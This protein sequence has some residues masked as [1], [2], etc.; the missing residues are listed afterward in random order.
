MR[1]AEHAPRG[2][3]RLL[4]C[5]H[6]LPEIAEGGAVV[7]SAVLPQPGVKEKGK[8]Y[9]ESR[10]MWRESRLVIMPDCQGLGLG[11][12]ISDAVAKYFIVERGGRFSSRTA[13]PRFGSY[14][15]RSARE[16]PSP[17]GGSA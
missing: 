4:K 13:H 15:E 7:F 3:F 10:T 12:A 17:G 9:E 5:L 16:T 1:A 8:S 11:P 2:P 14:R 6:G